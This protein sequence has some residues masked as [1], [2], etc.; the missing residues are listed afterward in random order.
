MDPYL[1]HPE[2][3]PD[4]H[5]ALITYIREYLQSVLPQPYYAPIGRRAWIELSKRSIQPEV[6]VARLGD[7]RKPPLKSTGGVALAQHPTARSVVIHVPHDEHREPF[8]E[9]YLGKGQDR[10]LVT[11]LEVLSPSNK[12]AGTQGRNLYLRKQREVLDSQVN[13][14]EIDLLRGGVH[15]TAVPLDEF[16]QN[17]PKPD[18]HVCVHAFDRLEDFVVYPIALEDEL[19]TI[20]IPLLPGEGAVPLNLLS[21]FHRCYDTGPYARE[22]DYEHDQPEPS[23]TPEQARWAE[24]LIRARTA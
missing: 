13:L 15:A 22:I 19:P 5:D 20:E 3:F 17:I 4:V 24:S 12:A 23:L 8:V 2:I 6:N 18:Y 9:I 21:V 11:H 14:V 1:E 16:R 10:R 7:S